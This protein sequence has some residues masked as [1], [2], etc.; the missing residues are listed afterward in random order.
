MRRWVW[1]FAGLLGLVCVVLAAGATYEWIQSRRDLEAAPPPGRLIDIGGHRLHLWCA[2]RGAPTVIFESGLGGTSFDWSAVLPDVS[3]FATAC[4]YDRAGMGYSDSGPSPRTSRRIV[5]E[6]AELVRR[7][8]T[9][10]PVV[11]VGWSDGGLY[12][13]VYASEHE[14][15]VAGCVPSLVEIASL[16]YRSC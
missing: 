8:E 14:S 15:Q 16:A 9:K 6:L 2:G 12:V 3:D 11:L 13:R 5:G 1:R 7:S 4:A 10:L